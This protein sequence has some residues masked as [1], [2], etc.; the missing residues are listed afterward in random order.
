M[1][2]ILGGLGAAISWAIANLASSRGS[3]SVGP[4]RAL[5]WVSLIGLVAAL[6]LLVTD[7]LPGP[8]DEDALLLL[9]VAG[10]G[11]G[12]GLLILYAA[13]AR[14]PVGIAAPIASTE[15]AIAAVIALVLGEQAGP[16][17][18]GALALVVV[19]IVLSTLQPPAPPVAPGPAGTVVVRE[20]TVDAAFVALAVTAAI[21][22]GTGLYA[23]GRVS[24]DVPAGWV[25]VAG[26]AA[27]LLLVGVPLVL[28]R[29]LGIPRRVL[30]LVAI[31][32]LA[33]VVG[34]VSYTVGARDG[35]AVAAVISSQFAV[36]TMI[37]AFLLF[38]ERL[39]RRQ[40]VGV[41]L[42]GAGVA[43]VTLLR[44]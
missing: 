28:G 22:F 21:L 25:V 44:V 14:G 26:R 40:V 5:A 13:F 2:A 4:Q 15:G 35:I 3:R 39:A 37:G 42:V 29:R 17:L 20:Y 27:G 18:V 12:G 33:E 16:A 41:I 43:V 34:M 30:P 7:R 32:G 9:V 19:G 1:I 38:G 11:Y 8:G 36:L 31:G 10:A 24:A 6:P 23:A